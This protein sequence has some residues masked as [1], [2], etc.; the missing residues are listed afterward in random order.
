MWYNMYIIPMYFMVV[1]FRSLY[2]IIAYSCNK[3]L[4]IC[5]ASQYCFKSVDKKRMVVYNVNVTLYTILT[6]KCS[7][8]SM[9]YVK[10]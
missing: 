2:D 4:K 8:I 10:K 7:Y 6:N 1:S 5:D 9:V 3:I